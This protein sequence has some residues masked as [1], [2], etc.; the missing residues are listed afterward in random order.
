V[1]QIYPFGQGD[2]FVE[3][4]PD[5]DL[6][7]PLQLSLPADYALGSDVLK[8]FATVGT[9]NFRWLEL[10]ALDDH[11]P[12]GPRGVARSRGPANP[13]ESLLA[14]VAAEAPPTRDA[15]VGS[16]AT[17]EWTTAQVEVRIRQ[18]VP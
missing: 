13:L 8:V 12:P 17:H 5:Q 2:Y 11:T 3:V 16:T 6:V 14:A 9:T 15:R 1:T 10:P 7:I 18:S 4:E